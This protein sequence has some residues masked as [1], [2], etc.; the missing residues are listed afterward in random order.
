M[1]LWWW[2]WW[3]DIICFTSDQ[4]CSVLLPTV[5]ESTKR[6]IRRQFGSQFWSLE[7]WTGHHFVKVN[8]RGID[9]EHGGL[10]SHDGFYL[11]QAPLACMLICSQQRTSKPGSSVSSSMLYRLSN[12]S[13]W[14]CGEWQ[15]HCIICY[16]FFAVS[17]TAGFLWPI[18]KRTSFHFLY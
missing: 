7:K 17:L 13:P 12:Q 10:C 1:I 2:M 9:R 18:G 3:M 5:R 8:P 15:Q 11:H 14:F 4:L 16:I 6:L